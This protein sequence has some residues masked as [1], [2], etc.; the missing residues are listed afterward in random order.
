MKLSFI[1]GF[2]TLSVCAH[3]QILVEDFTTP[4]LASLY[5]TW[6]GGAGVDAAGLRTIGSPAFANGGS[7]HGFTADVSGL[8]NAKLELKFRPDAGNA[9][10]LVMVLTQN[11][12]ATNSSYRYYYNVPA[13]AFTVGVMGTFLT[14]N[15]TAP[16]FVLDSANGFNSVS[17]A[18]APNLTKIQ[19]F[20]IQGANFD[21]TKAVR[22][23]FDNIAVVPEP[24]TMAALGL[25]VAAMLRRRKSAK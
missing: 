2:T 13:S 15:L 10:D 17:N 7:F 5:G 18:G 24:A 6:S 8:A 11:S 21:G 16:A 20:E 19:S 25:G 22:W 23:T 1:L 4:N 12:T 14:S 9:S 3:A